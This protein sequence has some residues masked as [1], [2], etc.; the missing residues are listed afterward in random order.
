LNEDL[1]G[2]A[3]LFVNPANH[4]QCHPLFSIQYFA[5]ARHCRRPGHP[6]AP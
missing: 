3:V 5:R 6:T 2:D 4:R 1:R